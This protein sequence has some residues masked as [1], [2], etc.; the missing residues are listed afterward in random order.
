MTFFAKIL[1]FSIFSKKSRLERLKM[2]LFHLF[3]ITAVSWKIR[4]KRPRNVTFVH[5][6]IINFVSR[7]I[8][9]KMPPAPKWGPWCPRLLSCLS[10]RISPAA[11]ASIPALEVR[12]ITTYKMLSIRTMQPLASYENHV[13]TWNCY[14]FCKNGPWNRHAT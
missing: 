7:N 12:C 2:S 13:R 8:R 3:L 4:G 9:G 10:P 14:S 1:M 6:S 11:W 5:F